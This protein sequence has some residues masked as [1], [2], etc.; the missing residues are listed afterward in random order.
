VA[1]LLAALAVGRR[2]DARSCRNACARM[3]DDQDEL[4]TGG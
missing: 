1:A 2:S 3:E 4:S